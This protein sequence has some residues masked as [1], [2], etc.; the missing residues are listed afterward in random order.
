MR[1]LALLLT[2]LAL[3]PGCRP[4]DAP[5]P[6]PDATAT[7]S[8]SFPNEDTVLYEVFVRNFSEEGTFAA[9]TARLD[10][11]QALGVNTLWLM[12]IHPISEAERKGTLGSPYAIQDYK[13][14]NPL[15]GSE[16]DFRALVEAAHARE[17][18]VILDWVANH[19]GWDHAW[20]TDHPAYYT[21]DAAG[22]IMI[23][24]NDDGTPT[25]WTDVADLDYSNPEVRAAMIDALAY[26]VREFDIDGYRCDVA[27]MVPNDFWTEALAELRAIKPVFM[28]AEWSTADLHTEAGFDAT[29]GWSRYGRLKEVWNGDATAQS[30]VDLVIEEETTTFPEGALR[31]NFTTNHDETAWDETP[32]ALFGGAGGA[33]AAST[34]MLLLPGF[35]LVY[36]GQEFADPQRIPLFEKQPI[37]REQGEAGT[38]M[39][40]FFDDL[41]DLRASHE[42][43]VEGTASTVAHDQPETV[44]AYR[45]THG[46]TAMLVVTNTRPEAVTVTLE[47]APEGAESVFGTGTLNGAT[48]ALPAHG[49]SV[50]RTDG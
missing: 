9:V 37:Q 1:P 2:A 38:T 47:A 45:L 31:M 43:F 34:A 39:R 36:N 50:L 3:V 10:S 7:V 35:P 16:D 23:P 11:L 27:G 5:E 49:Y 26:W 44:I 12:P 20:A 28:L 29:Y 32:L 24:H 19:T 18:K 48:V 22:E 17:M 21:R 30:L 41:L 33:R 15:L 8:P 46:D 25:D 13:A 14:V 40:A 6:S 42:A 4:S